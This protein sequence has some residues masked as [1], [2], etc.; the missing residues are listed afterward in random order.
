MQFGIVMLV[1]Q[2]AFI[3]LFGIFVR[4]NGDAG[5]FGGGAN[6]SVSFQETDEE[7]SRLYPCKFNAVYG[8]GGI[9]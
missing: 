8:V 4:Y 9:D 6:S 5:G 1:A 7:L 2:I 3:V